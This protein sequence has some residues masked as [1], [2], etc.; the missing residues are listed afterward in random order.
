MIVFQQPR[1]QARIHRTTT[2]NAR[3]ARISLMSFLP[4]S[5][6][7]VPPLAANRQ[8]CGVR[9]CGRTSTYCRACRSSSRWGR[10]RRSLARRSYASGPR[11]VR[12]SPYRKLSTRMRHS[13]PQ[14]SVQQP[15]LAPPR[16]QVRGMRSPHRESARPARCATP[17]GAPR[18]RRAL[19]HS[20]SGHVPPGSAA[21]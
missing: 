18:A 7:S 21:C 11:G 3:N 1:L 17:S 9:A 8:S 4:I 12:R 6:R 5:P 13:Q 10:L 2:P 16:S 19:R 15:A 20:A 14:F